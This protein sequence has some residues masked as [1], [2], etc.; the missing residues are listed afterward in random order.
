MFHVEHFMTIWGETPPN[1]PRGTLETH[2]KSPFWGAIYTKDLVTRL[3]PLFVTG[4]HS[5]YASPIR[6]SRP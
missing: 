6:E 2:S 1:V 3:S 5:L 4:L